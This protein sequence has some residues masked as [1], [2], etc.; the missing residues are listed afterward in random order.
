MILSI[1]GGK[2]GTGKSTVAV[3]IAIELARYRDLRLGDLDVE[4]PND[5]ILLGVELDNEEPIKLMYPHI[6][7]DNCIK[8]G[9]CGRVCDTGAM[10][11]SREG[12]PLLLPRLCSGCRACYLV[13]PTEAILE[14]ERVVGYTYESLVKMDD[15]SFNLVTGVMF[16]GEEHT[17]PIVK[18]AKERLFRV[19]SDIYIIDTSAGTGNHV[20]IAIDRSDLLIA[21]TEPTPLGLHDLEMILEVADEL[22]LEKWIV[23]NRYGLGSIDKHLDLAKKYRVDQ[24]FKIPYSKVIF[25]SYVKGKPIVLYRRDSEE[26]LSFINIVDKIKEVYL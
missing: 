3:N 20:S 13:C 19:K 5:H 18:K 17:P 10:I 25:E 9:A 4:A 23:I 15:V 14:G 16:E 7:Y 8:C 26:A 24:V 1:S 6:I 11:I 2:G 22:G 12:L 21:V